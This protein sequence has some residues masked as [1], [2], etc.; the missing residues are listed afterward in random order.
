MV[1]IND[2][3]FFERCGHALPATQIVSR[4]GELLKAKRR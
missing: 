2:N 4:R 1:G 3:S